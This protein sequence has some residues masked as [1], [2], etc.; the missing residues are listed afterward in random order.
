MCIPAAA[1]DTDVG[2]ELV[3]KYVKKVLYSVHTHCN[4]L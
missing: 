3:S 1:V 4:K 2:G